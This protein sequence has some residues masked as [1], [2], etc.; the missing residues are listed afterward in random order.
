[1]NQNKNRVRVSVTK[2]KE[3][4]VVNASCQCFGHSFRTHSNP[5]CPNRKVATD[6]VTK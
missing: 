2:T 6:E 4:S 3:G 1:M 5:N